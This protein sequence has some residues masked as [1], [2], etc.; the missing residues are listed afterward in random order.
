[1]PAPA[2][3]SAIAR[4]TAPGTIPNLRTPMDEPTDALRPPVAGRA[5]IVPMRDE[6]ARIERSLATLAAS[7]LGTDDLELVLVDDGSVDA[8]ASV[9]RRAAARLGLRAQV[10]SLPQARGKGAAVQ[11]GMLATTAAVR[12]FVDA[13]LCVDTKDLVRCFETLEAGT[14][15]VAYGT[16][17][18]PDSRLPRS[19][20]THRVASGRTYNLLL[21]RLG[22]TGE[23]DTQCGMKGFTGPAAEAIF[24]SLQTP[25]FGFDVEVLARA[26]RGGWRTDPIPVT[27][28]HVDGSRVRA[29]RDG[30]A[31][32][33]SALAVRRRLGREAAAARPDHV[34]GD[35]AHDAMDAM[36]RVERDHW[37][38]RAKRAIVTDQLER[39][40]ATDGPLRW[41]AGAP[42]WAS[43]PTGTP[44]SSPPTSC[45]VPGWSRAAPA[46]CRCGPA[47]RRPSPPSTSSST[48]T[49]T[50]RDCASWLAWPGMACWS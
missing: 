12:V 38:F 42:S 37:W 13:D 31:M 25:G 14:A 22:L 44:S 24:G 34:P 4:W 18:H 11:A 45:P 35:M 26:E 48:S 50:S 8:T 20:P 33:A 28:S 41:A 7:S 9:A 17:A 23:R 3:R 6:V 43:N 36:A 27:W 16:R 10:L 2:A 29:L 32:G 5:L 15:D 30:V 40:G 47:A 49:M 19:Q 1:M 39:F 21:R 46:S